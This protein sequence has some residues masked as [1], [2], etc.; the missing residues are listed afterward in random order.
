MLLIE[1]CE[2]AG[3]SCD[4]KVF[5]TD[6]AE[7][8]LGN[9]RNGVYPG[10]IEAEMPPE[11]LARFFDKNDAIYR[12]R[13]D[14]RERVVFAPQN[15]LND[16]PFS[17]LDIV[18]CRNLL[19]YLEPEMQLRVIALLH[20]GL[21]QGGA[22]FLGNSETVSGNGNLFEVIDKKARI[23]R[24]VGPTQHGVVEFPLPRGVVVAAESFRELARAVGPAPSVAQLTARA[25]LAQHIPAAVTVDRNYRV[26]YFQGNTKS[27]LTQPTGEP[28]Q[29][30][31]ALVSEEMRGAVRATLQRA[32]AKNAIVTAPAGWVID[33]Q[34]QRRRVVVAVSPLTDNDSTELF[35]VS[36]QE[37]EE[38]QPEVPDGVGSS[39]Q[40]HAQSPEALQRLRDE[41]QSTV[42]ELQASNE[43]HNASAE[44]AMSVNEEL[45]STN[46][47]LETSK[48]EMQSLNEEL[49]T[50]NAQLHAKMEEL[51]KA[52][53]DLRSLLSSTDI[54][55][56]FLDP[57]FRIRRYTPAARNLLEL[58]GSGRR[59]SVER[60]GQKV[61]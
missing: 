44:E 27:Y 54:A 29:D 17:R 46:E 31:L 41:L 13:Q 24:R 7:R 33:E 58:L 55:V 56:I 16:P 15:V 34:G 60:P 28:T 30:L 39:A 61:R 48:E 47:E 52:S 57:Q 5:A 49:S 59:A 37:R 4:I 50:V 35:V 51:Q 8:T 18:T 23:Y 14:L 25:L 1:E 22:L 36:F 21:R 3:K 10:G 19:I 6:T 26:L 9:A 11:R 42:E 38:L 12:V 53:G 43:E 45:Q 20:F 2:H 40:E 32:F